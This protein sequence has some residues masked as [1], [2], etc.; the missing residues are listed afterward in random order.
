MDQQEM[1]VLTDNIYQTLID[2]YREEIIETGKIVNKRSQIL[3][4][5]FD[6]YSKKTSF[7]NSLF[8][9][10][11]DSLPDYCTSKLTNE[12]D[13]IP[14]CIKHLDLCVLTFV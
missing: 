3:F 2:K 8:Y 4:F 9:I 12:N 7:Q 11:L 14:I 13:E 10:Y 5:D 6:L 1:E